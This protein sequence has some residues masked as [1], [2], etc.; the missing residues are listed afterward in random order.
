M[1]DQRQLELIPGIY[2]A[3]HKSEEFRM[4][5]ESI[6]KKGN[7]KQKYIDFLTSETSMEAYSAAYTSELVDEVNKLSGY[8]TAWR[9]F[10]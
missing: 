6:L 5:I 7:L 9:P 4:H 10:W 1:S 2:F 8:G 3:K